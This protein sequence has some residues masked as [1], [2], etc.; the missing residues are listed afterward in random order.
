VM[1]LAVVLV[2]A[3]SLRLRH[4][5]IDTMV[6]LGCSRR[7]IAELVAAELSLILVIS[8]GLTTGLTVGTVYWQTAMLQRLLF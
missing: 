1:L 8:L 4:T 5:E 2:M 7:K 3:L 6:K